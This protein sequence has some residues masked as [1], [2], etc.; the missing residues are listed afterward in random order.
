MYETFS[1]DVKLQYSGEVRQ[2]IVGNFDC[3]GYKKGYI[4]NE[5]LGIY[6]EKN[7]NDF[8]TL[9]ISERVKKMRSLQA[10]PACSET[11]LRK[12]KDT[13]NSLAYH[14]NLGQNAQIYGEYEGKLVKIIK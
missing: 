4:E 1:E 2:L 9:E 12:D 6:F 7:D 13:Y 3:R 5:K 8:C 11:S 10:V 14:L